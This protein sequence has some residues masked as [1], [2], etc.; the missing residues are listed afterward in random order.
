MFVGFASLCRCNKNLY[1][2]LETHLRYASEIEQVTIR[3]T[4]DAL[5][6]VEAVSKSDILPYFTQELR[7]EAVE[8]DILWSTKELVT[9]LD[10]YPLC[11]ALNRIQMVASPLWS[12][13]RTRTY[14]GCFPIISW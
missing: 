3:S 12:L 5:K 7:F 1:S 13:P 8:S 10:R 4:E 2:K 11:P 6:W 9:R 14:H